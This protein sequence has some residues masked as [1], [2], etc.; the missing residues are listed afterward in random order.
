MRIAFLL[1]GFYRS[2]DRVKYRYEFLANYYRADVF[3]S[4]WNRDEWASNKDNYT[5]EITK[6][7]FEDF[8]RHV[9]VEALD[10]HDLDQ[11]KINRQSFVSNIRNN[12]VL[13]TDARAIEHGIFWANRLRDQ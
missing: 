10:I 11:Y 6:N 4:T 12:D 13:K 9:N 7:D 2:F 1:T 8:S 5:R 3:I